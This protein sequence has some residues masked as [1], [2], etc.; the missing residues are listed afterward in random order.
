[1]EALRRLPA[2]AGMPGTRSTAIT[3][4]PLDVRARFSLRL[5][6]A[7]A[8]DAARPIPSGLNIPV[9]TSVTVSGR[10]AARLGPDEW[11]LCGTDVERLVRELDALLQGQCYS[12]VDIGHRHAAFMVAGTHA[13][14]AINA[15]CP[16]D[17]DDAAFPPDGA[18][19]TGLD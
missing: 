3:I 14:V 15:G 10:I 13:R 12:I 9:N 19:R 8:A 1:M 5:R 2:S 7:T 11:I 4:E 16:L 17:S 6:L 18:T